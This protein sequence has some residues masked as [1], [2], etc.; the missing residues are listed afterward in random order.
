MDKQGGSVATVKVEVGD[1]TGHS[2]YD[3]VTKIEFAD[4][5][6]R[7]GVT[8]WVF[9]ENR[10]PADHSD[11]KRWY[12]SPNWPEKVKTIRFLPALGP[13]KLPAPEEGDLREMIRQHFL[14]AVSREPQRAYSNS[15]LDEIVSIKP[16][17]KRDLERIKGMGPR[18]MQSWEEI[19]S[20]VDNYLIQR[21]IHSIKSADLD[22]LYKTQEI[23]KGG[24]LRDNYR[25][26]LKPLDDTQIKI[27]SQLSESFVEWSRGRGEGAKWNSS[28]MAKRM[29]LEELTLWKCP[30]CGNLGK[31]NFENIGVYVDDTFQCKKCEKIQYIKDGNG[32]SDVGGIRE[33]LAE[34]GLEYSKPRLSQII[35]SMVDEGLVERKRPTPWVRGVVNIW[36]TQEGQ[37]MVNSSD[38]EG[39]GF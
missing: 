28:K 24:Q 21:C 32:H 20:I 13:Q 11:V 27:I 7:N 9:L 18:R 5:Y 12:E 37:K 34:R 26:D 39:W 38:G 3:E 23:L 31:G 4:L 6:M 25:I 30:D 35:S 33:K 36:I 22:R 2:T 17:T 29:I 19:V 10:G 16:R 8:D 15:L 14:S 1:N